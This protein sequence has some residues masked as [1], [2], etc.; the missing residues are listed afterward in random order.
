MDKLKDN[1]NS[2]CTSVIKDPDGEGRV[3]ATNSKKAFTAG[4]ISTLRL[5]R[6]RSMGSEGIGRVLDT[7]E[8]EIEE[9]MNEIR[10]NN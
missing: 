4:A 1:W 9:L 5:L 2:Y 10:Q 7:F 8:D 3:S 6:D